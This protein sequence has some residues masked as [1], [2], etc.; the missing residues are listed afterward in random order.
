MV[1]YLDE[2]YFLWHMALPEQSTFLD[3][4]GW[5]GDRGEQ[6]LV[7]DGSGLIIVYTG[8]GGDCVER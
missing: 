6:R 4:N 2:K 7:A 3:A 5:P 1:N 8:A